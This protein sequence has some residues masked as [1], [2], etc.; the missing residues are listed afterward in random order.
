VNA[1]RSGDDAL[2]LKAIK[3][4]GDLAVNLAKITTGDGGNQV[5]VQILVQLRE[6]ME[7]MTEIFKEALRH[8][9]D[10]QTALRIVTY[11]ERRTAA[12]TGPLSG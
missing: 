10:P 3:T 4:A 9:T 11:I 7:Q 8:E 12:L 1:R 6:Q 5:T 2:K